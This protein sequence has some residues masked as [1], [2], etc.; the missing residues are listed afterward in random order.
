[1]KE[2]LRPKAFYT[3]QTIIDGEITYYDVRPSPDLRI[4]RKKAFDIY[5][6]METIIKEIDGMLCIQLF[7]DYGKGPDGSPCIENYY[8]HGFD[9]TGANGVYDML[10]EGL[11]FEKDFLQELYSGGIPQ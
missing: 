10:Y 7:L 9:L 8:I 3:I 11:E 1:M 2:G 6:A 5:N 4:D